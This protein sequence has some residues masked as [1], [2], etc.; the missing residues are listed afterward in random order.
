MNHV[1]FV[2]FYVLGT[3]LLS[4]GPLSKGLETEV[5]DESSKL[6]TTAWSQMSLGVS[7]LMGGEAHSYRGIFGGCRVFHQATLSCYPTLVS[8]ALQDSTL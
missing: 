8:L 6:I 7:P 4:W 5:N 1:L 2:L 3:G